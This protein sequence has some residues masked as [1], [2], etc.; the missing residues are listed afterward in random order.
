[1]TQPRVIFVFGSN[2]AGIHGGGAA[3]EA[4]A[5]WGARPKVASGLVGE[6]YAIPTCDK[7]LMPLP[8]D[9]I[10]RHVATFIGCAI[11]HPDLTF[12]VTP[13]GCGIAGYSEGQMAPM[14]AGAPANVQLPKGWRT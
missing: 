2:L 1:M 4:Q 10:R 9:E 8:L 11:A 5:H 12:F 3:R 13:I 14:F 7:A 6:S